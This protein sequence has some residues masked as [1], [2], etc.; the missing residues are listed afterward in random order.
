MST[1]RARSTIQQE[2]LRG[3]GKINGKSNDA[4]SAFAY[5]VQ[6]V[7]PYHYHDYCITIII[8]IITYFL[9]SHT[10]SSFGA[11]FIP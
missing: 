5:F 6:H 7:P 11:E 1:D 10:L 9:W 4:S 2:C 3:W 8:V